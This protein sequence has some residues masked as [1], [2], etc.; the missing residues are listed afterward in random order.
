M[1]TTRLGISDFGLGG[2]PLVVPLEL[3]RVHRGLEGAAGRER[4][5]MARA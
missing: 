3:L 5:G 4:G 2:V 1:N